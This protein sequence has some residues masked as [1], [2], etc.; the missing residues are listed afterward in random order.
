MIIDIEPPKDL[1]VEL[2]ADSLVYRVGGAIDMMGEGKHFA[3]R[4]LDTA[5]TNIYEDTG[6]S[7]CKIYLGT[8]TNYRIQ[9]A[10]LYKYK[11][12]RDNSRRPMY[13]D[14][15]RAR[16]ISE[17]QAVSVAD[18]EAEDQVGIEAYK[19]DS[20]EK[21]IVGAIDKDMLMIAGRHYNY[22]QRKIQV[23]DKAQALRQFYTQL[24]TGD[25][26]VDNIPGLYHCLLS[27]KQ[28]EMAHKFRYSRYKSRLIKALDEM[29]DEMSM[30]EHV[31]NLYKV[32]GQVD[33]HEI[34]RILEIGRLLW[35]R[36]YEGELWVPPIARDFDYIT[37]DKREEI[38]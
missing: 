16:L 4:M 31:Y 20:F 15:L 37:N 30:W 12:N 25:K 17:Y 3:C 6:C 34:S 5:I 1:T 23:I 21:F 29:E 8:S 36:R 22:A 19:Y 27:D 10:K 18:Q 28:D 38:E 24:V 33:K 35:I 26:S 14:A 9:I 32:W 11:A 13:Y 2:D 7:K